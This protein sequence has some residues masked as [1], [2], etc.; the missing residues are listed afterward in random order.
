MLAQNARTPRPRALQ[1]PLLCSPNYTLAS[2][3]S[4][5]ANILVYSTFAYLV[6]LAR[7]SIGLLEGGGRTSRGGQPL[8]TVNK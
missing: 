5:I 7:W 1:S 3:S 8:L 2:Q 4:R 6:L